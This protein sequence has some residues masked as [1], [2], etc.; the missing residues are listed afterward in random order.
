MDGYWGL[1][2]SCIGLQPLI[3]YQDT[4]ETQ[5]GLYQNDGK[6]KVRRRK[7]TSHDPKQMT[8]CV[9]HE[10]DSQWKEDGKEDK[11]WCVWMYAL[12]LHSGDVKTDGTMLAVQMDNVSKHTQ[13]ILKVTKWFFNVWVSHLNLTQLS[14]FSD[15]ED[16]SEGRETHKQGAAEGGH[17]L[18]DNCRL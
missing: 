5:I 9:Q 2:R 13:E 17:H 7:G 16:K 14:S 12:G 10:G 4:N 1:F 3:L 18:S 6:R 11:S 8:S 15:A